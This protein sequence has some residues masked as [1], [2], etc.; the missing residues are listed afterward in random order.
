MTNID[1]LLLIDV[2]QCG[3]E[4]IP[5]IGVD[6]ANSSN[7]IRVVKFDIIIII[8]IFNLFYSKLVI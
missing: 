6:D 1:E 3:L 5:L 2:D 7:V 8:I 4:L